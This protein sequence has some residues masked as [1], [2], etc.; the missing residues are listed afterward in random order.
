MRA[1]S[2]TPWF[3]VQPLG[4]L[5]P[6]S[7][8][9]RVSG[10][11]FRAPHRPHPEAGSTSRPSRGPTPPTTTGT[12]AWPHRLS[13]HPPDPC[14]TTTTTAW[15][16]CPSSSSSNSKWS[17]TTST[18]GTFTWS[19]PLKVANLTTS[20]QPRPRLPTVPPVQP[21]PTRPTCPQ[22]PCPRTCLTDPAK[23][24]AMLS[25]NPSRRPS[26]PLVRTNPLYNK[27][28]Q[29]TSTNLLGLVGELAM[30]FHPGT[31]R[32]I[33]FWWRL[34][35]LTTLTAFFPNDILLF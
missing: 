30:F 7:T 1:S 3:G 6:R 34:T 5:S 9:P 15:T 14:T 25:P 27:R 10:T 12:T 22:T 35:T 21:P 20:C 24:T 13:R 23:A 28:P 33:F 2:T 4:V 17:L 26:V 8:T 16:F 29:L 11:R 32:D 19:G 31:K 18:Q